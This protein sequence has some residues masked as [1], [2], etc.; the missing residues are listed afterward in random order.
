MAILKVEIKTDISPMCKKDE[1]IRTVDKCRKN[2][3]TKGK[4][5]YSHRKEK[6]KRDGWKKIRSMCMY[7]K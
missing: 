4:R 7:Y 5:D 2:Q 6:I 1:R 3:Y